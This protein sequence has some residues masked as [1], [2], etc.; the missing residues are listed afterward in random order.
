MWP[1]SWFRSKRSTTKE[2]E[3]DRRTSV[4]ED[5]ELADGAVKK[6]SERSQADQSSTND[7]EAKDKGEKK[8]DYKAKEDLK[9]KSFVG[10]KGS[11][12]GFATEPQQGGKVS[13]S[14]VS[15]PLW[16]WGR[17]CVWGG[18]GML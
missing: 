17:V 11:N 12:G 18:G 15:W 3:E 10:R 14:N 8:G 6:I 9:K 1:M 16:G 2:D 5:L 7:G 13:C 4:T